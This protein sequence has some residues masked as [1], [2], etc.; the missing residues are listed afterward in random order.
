MITPYVCATCSRRMIRA[1][2]ALVPGRM[3]VAYASSHAVDSILSN[4][5]PSSRPDRQPR[6]STSHPR[7]PPKSHARE[8]RPQYGKEPIRGTGDFTSYLTNA[9]GRSGRYSRGPQHGASAPVDGAD[10]LTVSAPRPKRSYASELEHLLAKGDLSQA[11]S[12]F[13]KHYSSKDSPPL[14]QPSFKDVPKVQSRAVFY[15]LLARITSAWQDQVHQKSQ[16][17]ELP[18]PLEVVMKFEELG[19]AVPA[20]YGRSLFSMAVALST[21]LSRE[22][23]PG[24]S[25][26]DDYVRQLMELWA[27]M[28]T[29]K[30]RAV[31]VKE[32]LDDTQLTSSLSFVLSHSFEQRLPR[33][34]GSRFG[35]L[36]AL[37]TQ[38]TPSGAGHFNH[39]AASS[40]VTYD[41]LTH[42]LSQRSD[43]PGNDE[44]RYAGF[45]RSMKTLFSNTI[46][47]EDRMTSLLE[48]L[49]KEGMGA[50]TAQALLERLRP[51]VR[52][53]MPS[54]NDGTPLT[55]R[56][57]TDSL[58]RLSIQ[59]GRALEGEDLDRTEKL[60]NETL[61]LL[62]TLDPKLSGGVHHLKAHEEF[63]RAFFRL[64]RPQSAIQIW[65]SMT[66]FGI[67]PTLRT[68][69]VM[70]KGCHISRDIHIMES[71]W[72]RMRASGLQ[73][74]GQA[75][76]T[77]IYG[78]LR[79]GKVEEGLKAMDEMAREWM[80][81]VN[82][83]SKPHEAA[84]MQADGPVANA[85]KPNT[86]ILNTAL[87]ALRGRSFEHI[88]KLLTWSR[89]FDIRPDIITYNILLNVS[90]AEGQ[91]EQAVQILQSMAAAK[92]QPNSET[93]TIL[94]TSIFYATVLKDMTH[95]EQEDYI[96]RFI[97]SFE[98]N[99]IEIDNKGYALLI[100]RLL[101]EYKN[102]SA[103]QKILALMASKKIEPTP[104]IYTIL[105]THYFDATPPNLHAVDALW[106]QIQSHGHYGAPLDVIFY[107]RMVEGYARH[108]DVGRTMAFLTRMSKEGKRPGW[109]AMISVAKCLSEKGDWDRLKQVVLD[110]HKQEGLLSAG[111]HGN[112]G[113]PEF[114]QLVKNLGVLDHL[115]I[116]V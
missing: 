68:W 47:E 22:A 93:I 5:A 80:N 43:S 14:A 2:G 71:M 63:L 70:M 8:S 111:L 35:D 33:S 108:G 18:S 112:K 23:T 104:Y 65:N 48:Q 26:D 105:V 75:W 92:V 85:P 97:S 20:T 51:H 81:A 32:M 1:P 21:A 39:L 77:R 30:S 52:T 4:A 101:K 99:G 19:L 40:L 36:F 24:P 86:V 9:A 115:G 72:L 98:A 54:P 62:R 66:D 76:S 95:S 16:S 55:S 59:L 50:E 107:D 84:R 45:V 42:G 73:P 82:H 46:M 29:R 44:E 69:T 78:L 100:D 83:R 25:V 60:W 3:H 11:W 87:S 10:Q 56:D 28:L 13:T 64:R 12:F 114:W 103:A 61:K 38:S 89:N 96:M 88:P 31:E 102:V 116:H 94:L 58:H 106:N 49:V 7:A 79:V 15:K 91:Q 34:I 6:Y 27:R 113:Q 37:F 90:L 110:C 17:T 53:A 67:Q 109:L 41:I 57:A 74:D